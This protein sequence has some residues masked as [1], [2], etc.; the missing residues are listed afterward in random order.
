[1]SVDTKDTADTSKT[2][3]AEE[4]DKIISRV[5]PELVEER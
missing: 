4:I 1:M 5:S 2:R 3:G